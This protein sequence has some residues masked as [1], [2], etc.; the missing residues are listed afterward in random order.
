MARYF[1][2]TLLICGLFLTA[3]T[4]SDPAGSDS[5]KTINDNSPAT[6]GENTVEGSDGS[7]ITNTSDEN[8][9]SYAPPVFNGTT[10]KTSKRNNLESSAVLADVRTGKHKG[11]DRVVFEFKGSDMPGYYIE[12]IGEPITQCG[13]GTKVDLTGNGGLEI[14]FSPA[15]A[16]TDSGTPTIFFS[17]NEQNPSYTIIKK[18]R[19]TCD[20]EG[21]VTWVV[22]VSKANKYRVLTLENPTRLAVDIEH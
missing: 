5:N 12:Y 13:S 20:F 22:G 16:H 3:C 7:K 10:K 9:E 6:N 2:F 4:N 17:D 1:A 14:R 19:S 8:N 11:F 15:Q 18:L 21:N